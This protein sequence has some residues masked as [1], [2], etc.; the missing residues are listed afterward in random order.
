M[1]W[2]KKEREEKKG[3]EKKEIERRE[4]K[5]VRYRKRQKWYVVPMKVFRTIK[6]SNEMDKERKDYWAK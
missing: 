3:V 2:E 4:E 5:G 6:G 1:A